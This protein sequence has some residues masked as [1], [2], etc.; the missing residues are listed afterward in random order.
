MIIRPT[1][2][3]DLA[4]ITA[5]YADIVA[6][7]TASYEYEVPDEAEMTRRW[8]AL[9]EAGYPYLTA[10]IDGQLA[11]FAYASSFRQRDG[12]RWVVED[13]VYIDPRFQRR[14][15]GKALLE[16]LISLCTQ[17]G[18]RHMVAAIGDASY[19]ASIKL[20]EQLGFRTI[21]QIPGLGWKQEAW[22]DWVLMQRE[23]GDGTTTPPPPLV[24]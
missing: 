23:L 14:G 10:E 5:L 6:H 1:E 15:I 17:K 8:Q 13:S 7:G 24:E 19:I 22:Q 4:A 16:E 12:Y 18:Y 3:K 11:G 21:G 9:T 20:H 2:T